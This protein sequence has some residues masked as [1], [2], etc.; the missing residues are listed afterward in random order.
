MPQETQRRN[1]FAV[2]PS[3]SQFPS[4][5]SRYRTSFSEPLAK[6]QPRLRYEGYR[7]ALE[8]YGNESEAK[9]GQ[10]RPTFQTW[11][12]QNPDSLREFRLRAIA[13]GFNPHQGFIDRIHWLYHHDHPRWVRDNTT[14]DETRS[15]SPDMAPPTPRAT[16]GHNLRG[17]N[18]RFIPAAN[19]GPETDT[20]EEFSKMSGL[21]LGDPTDREGTLIGRTEM[22]LIQAQL[23]DRLVKAPENRRDHIIDRIRAVLEAGGGVNNAEACVDMAYGWFPKDQD[24]PPVGSTLNR[25]RVRSIDLT[26]ETPSRRRLFGTSTP[27]T[28]SA[29]QEEEANDPFVTTAKRDAADAFLDNLRR[30]AATPR[31]KRRQA[32]L[33]L[34]PSRDNTAFILETTTMDKDGTT[35]A[36][37][38]H[39]ANQAIMFLDPDGAENFAR[40][41][42]ACCAKSHPQCSLRQTARF[43]GISTSFV[44][45]LDTTLNVIG[46]TQEEANQMAIEAGQHRFFTD[47]Q[48]ATE[49]VANAME[50]HTKHTWSA[51]ARPNLIVAG[52]G[53]T[54]PH[55]VPGRAVA[56]RAT[57]NGKTAVAAKPAPGLDP[58]RAPA[59][60]LDDTKLRALKFEDLLTN[61]TEMAAIAAEGLAE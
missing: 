30:G 36:W 42:R 37:I 17:R 47:E 55:Y 40:F 58:L 11:C 57:T 9:S 31:T 2:P 35:P 27:R 56:L 4:R 39:A 19:R 50:F 6:R 1:S 51:T 28:P 22:A 26:Q 14:P 23:M 53:R 7:R 20:P 49:A 52:S 34:L 13:E 54:D 59:V 16:L 41:H 18:G 32:G 24:E 12:D 29:G 48:V 3:S 43:L 38:V 8:L 44:V 25:D 46:V 33:E 10:H 45:I 5:D 15:A 21:V 60:V 61:T